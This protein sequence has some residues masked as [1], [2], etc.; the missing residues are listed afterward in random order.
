MTSAQVNDKDGEGIAKVKVGDTKEI[1]L[2]RLS[3]GLGL[4]VDKYGVG[5]TDADLIT[6]DDALYTFTPV[7]QQ[8]QPDGKLRCC[9]CTLVFKCCLN[10]KILPIRIESL[11]N[12][13]LFVFYASCMY[14]Y[15][16]LYLL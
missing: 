10:T 4:L 16:A 3:Q 6:A 9:F 14:A 11:T 5:L 12:G 1:A 13:D 2:N 8:P 15:Y 7:S